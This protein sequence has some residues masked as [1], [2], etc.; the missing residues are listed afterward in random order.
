[1]FDICLMCG[2]RCQSGDAACSDW[3]YEQLEAARNDITMMDA[4]VYIP[5]HNK[6]LPLPGEGQ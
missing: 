4:D 6:Q 2:E 1:M 3:C 5:P